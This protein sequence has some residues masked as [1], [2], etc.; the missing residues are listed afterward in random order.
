MSKILFQIKN[1]KLLVEER[2]RVK[3]QE[4]MLINTNIISRDELLFSEEYINE[5]KILIHNFI[6]EI[7]INYHIDTREFIS[8]E[9]LHCASA[10]YL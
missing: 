7:V 8:F 3:T 1:N 9:T 5:N 2:K 6:K 4:K 10:L